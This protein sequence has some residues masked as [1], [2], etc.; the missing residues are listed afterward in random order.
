MNRLSRTPVIVFSNL[1]PLPLEAPRFE[2]K[3]RRQRISNSIK[4][5]PSGKLG[6]LGAGFG[7]CLVEDGEPPWKEGKGETRAP[8]VRYRDLRMEGSDQPDNHEVE[9]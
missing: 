2:M 5:G 3:L 1:G 8:T 6:V 7:S 9:V 4:T